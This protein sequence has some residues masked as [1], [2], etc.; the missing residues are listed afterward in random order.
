MNKPIIKI[1]TKCIEEKRLDEFGNATKGKDGKKSVCKNCEKIYREDNKKQIKKQRKD[2]RTNNK[3]KMKQR[4]KKSYIKNKKYIKNK[5]NEYY[6]NNTEKSKT[7]V[8]I[9]YKKNRDKIN[10]KRK[11]YSKIYRDK[12]KDIINEKIKKRRK[13]D[14]IFKLN[15]QICHAFRQNIKRK[16]KIKKFKNS[17]FDF[18]NIQECIN[19]LIHSPKWEKYCSGIEYQID[20]LIP[21]SIYNFENPEDIKRCWNP[22]NLQF[23]TLAENREKSNTINLDLIKQHKI[24]HLLPRD[25]NYS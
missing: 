16:L 21:T 10:A 23:L 2:Y 6:K 3:D 7:C 18:F 15:E 4:A 24:K 13:T 8:K 5:S 1:C 17:E 11:I 12:N 20:H 14:P 9:Y 22:R 19:H 25:Y